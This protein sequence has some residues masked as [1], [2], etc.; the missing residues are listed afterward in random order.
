[1]IWGMTTATFTQVHVI[2]SL[3]GIGSGLLVAYGLLK[4]K[5]FAGATAIFLL[6]TVLT[7]VT[8][9]AFPNEHVTPGIIVG[10]ISMVLLTIAIAARHLFHLGGIWRSLYVI[11]AM[12][13]LYLNCFVL[14]VQLFEKV[15][16][17]KTLGLQ[18]P[19]LAAQVPVLIL[20]LVLTIVAVKNFR[21][22]LNRA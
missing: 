1:M 15:P 4:G 12:M 17:L 14:V 20:F 7:S 21:S 2:I 19:F 3:I 22:A 16:S 5:G 13:A 8:G 11:T 10:I 9:F 18:P 6:T